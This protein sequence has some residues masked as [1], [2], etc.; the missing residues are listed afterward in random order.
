MTT[1]RRRPR[2]TTLAVTA[3]A[4]LVVA[5]CA[6]R[7][8][9]VRS[10]EPRRERAVAAGATTTSAADVWDDDPSEVTDLELDGLDDPGVLATVVRLVDQ[11]RTSSSQPPLRRDDRLDETARKTIV[12]PQQYLDLFSHEYLELVHDE[13]GAEAWTVTPLYF[14]LTDDGTLDLSDPLFEQAILDHF[15]ADPLNTRWGVAVGRNDAGRRQLAVVFTG[16][17]PTPDQIAAAH[18]WMVDGFPIA[19]DH[20]ALAQPGHSDD[21]DRVAR[22]LNGSTADVTPIVD[23]WIRAHRRPLSYGCVETRR[24]P[25]ATESTWGFYADDPLGLADPQEFGVAIARSRDRLRFCTVVTFPAPTPDLIERWRA[26]QLRSVDGQ[27]DMY[28]DGSTKPQLDPRLAMAA[29]AEAER[30][31][32]ALVASDS[33]APV[34]APP[35]VR[36]WI[37][38]VQRTVRVDDAS[39]SDLL[40]STWY[41]VGWAIDPTTGLTMQ[42]VFWQ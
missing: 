6:D 20:S 9:V 8:A 21:L 28:G 29:Q 36:S 32:R 25:Y 31:L 22:Q 17:E 41:G 12:G 13:L 18:D 10:S 5:S 35:G 39:I 16:A 38:G 27:L 24:P 30:Q 14:E 34:E 23:A 42:V 15:A 2:P 7:G 33:I 40:A 4:V 1:P 19:R 3:L 37:N 26:E 11:A